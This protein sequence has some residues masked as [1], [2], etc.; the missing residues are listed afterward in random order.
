MLD[1]EILPRFSEGP[2]RIH[3]SGVKTLG[4]DRVGIR[5]DAQD[6]WHHGFVESS[7]RHPRRTVVRRPVPHHDRAAFFFDHELVPLDPG[8]QAVHDLAQLIFLRRVPAEI[9]AQEDATLDQECGLDQIRCRRVGKLFVCARLAVDPVAEGPHLFF[10]LRI[11]ESPHAE[12]EVEAFLARDEAALDADHE[13]RHAHARGPDGRQ[14]FATGGHPSG[15]SLRREPA[16]RMGLLDV[17]TDPGLLHVL[18]QFIPVKWQGRC[19]GG[20]GPAARREPRLDGPHL[21]EIFLAGSPDKVGEAPEQGGRVVERGPGPLGGGCPLHLVAHG[22]PLRLP[23]QIHPQHPGPRLHGELPGVRDRGRNGTVPH[24]R[25]ERNQCE[26][27]P[28]VFCP[29][30][31][32]IPCWI[33]DVSH[34]LQGKKFQQP[35]RNV[36][37][38]SLEP[39]PGHLRPVGMP[40]RGV[41]LLCECV[42]HPGQRPFVRVRL[43]IFPATGLS[44]VPNLVLN[45]TNSNDSSPENFAVPRRVPFAVPPSYIVTVPKFVDPS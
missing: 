25:R 35:T 31:L 20:R 23:A 17:K 24:Q 6:V 10:G 34:F 38:P 42:Q 19:L 8:A 26:T 18:H 16:D 5:A 33:L 22:F 4:G 37:Y 43:L 14:G 27:A 29:S 39:P 2:P 3:P 30:S 21:I 41:R 7:D 28:P 9:L 45:P 12:R 11:E 32:D 44:S 40:R 15:R 36:Q 1:P 13:I